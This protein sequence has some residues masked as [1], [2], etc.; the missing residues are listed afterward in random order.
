[1]ILNKIF[2]LYINVLLR[3]VLN[4]DLEVLEDSDIESNKSNNDD[5][6]DDDD[7]LER[8]YNRRVSRRSRSSSRQRHSSGDIESN[9]SGA[10]ATG[11][12]L[13]KMKRPKRF[14]MSSIKSII[15]P[16]GPEM[17]LGV[18]RWLLFYQYIGL[19]NWFNVPFYLSIVYKLFVFGFVSYRGYIILLRVGE[20]D[21]FD[22]S[23]QNPIFL[24]IL[25]MSII[26]CFTHVLI[27][28]YT[29]SVKLSP[30]MKI[31]ETP[32][33]CFISVETQLCSGSGSFDAMLLFLLFHGSLTYMATFKSLNDFMD[34]FD[35]LEYLMDVWAVI[36]FTYYS[37]VGLLHMDFY[38]RSNFA[39]WLLTLRSLLEHRFAHYNKHQRHYANRLQQRNLSKQQQQPNGC[40]AIAGANREQ[41]LLRGRRYDSGKSQA[42]TTEAKC[43]PQVASTSTQAALDLAIAQPSRKDGPPEVQT[44]DNETL[45]RSQDD[46]SSVGVFE[47]MTHYEDDDDDSDSDYD[48]YD[49]EDGDD[50]RVC[51]A[52]EDDSEPTTNNYRNLQPRKRTKRL[53]KSTN[54]SRSQSSSSKMI[55]FV[56]LDEIQKQLNNM[57]DHLEVLRSMQS[58]SLVFV[59]LSA[60]FANGALILFIY[61]LLTSRKAYYH[62]TILTL[63]SINYIL[64]VFLCYIGD[65]LA[66]YGLS[67]FVQ[68]VEDE[69]FLQSDRSTSA[70]LATVPE[71]TSKQPLDSQQQQDTGDN[72]SST[73]A[74]ESSTSVSNSNYNK[75]LARRDQLQLQ[76]QQQQQKL[77]IKRKDVLF[78]REFLHQFENHLATPWTKLTVKTHLHIMGTFVT[79]IAAQIIFDHE[80]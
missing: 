1:M 13:C 3:P 70:A 19:I 47:P 51:G 57:D 63:T 10:S 74:M 24:F 73:A 55:Q 45:V 9:R 61:T 36:I 71:M 67:A 59:S 62:G 8:K 68:T 20:V 79:L 22:R 76:L 21:L 58:T 69:Y 12:D 16:N 56:S 60:F 75:R 29:S 78:C 34:L 6:G 30:L 64:I 38:I 54:D 18:Q 49:D 2:H 44:S 53:R 80:H 15:D 43:Q 35:P 32:K 31:L 4:R 23:F 42:Q 26:S 77:L 5:L 17:I 28:I 46:V 48:D 52:D 40:R 66:Y 41:Q 39:V 72:T 33:L 65:R 27:T 14:N 25:F 11:T 50:D 7:E 37:F